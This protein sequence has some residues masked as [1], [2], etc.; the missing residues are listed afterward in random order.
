ME[1]RPTFIYSSEDQPRLLKP[2]K[3]GED[4]IWYRP[5]GKTFKLENG[6]WHE[7]SPEGH[8]DA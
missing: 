1:T 4:H 3:P 5:D 2:A 7:W 6:V 8:L